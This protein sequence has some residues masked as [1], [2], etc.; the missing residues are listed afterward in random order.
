[1][2]ITGIIFCL[3]FIQMGVFTQE[4]IVQ[5]QFE[6]KGEPLS[7][8]KC[9]ADSAALVHEGKSYSKSPYLFS[10]FTGNGEGGLHLAYSYDGLKWESL[11][12]G[13]SFLKPE[14]GTD[15]LMRDPSVCVGP[16]GLFHMVWTSSWTDR[17]I[18]H[19]SSPDLI[20]W[21]K[22]QSI[23]VMMHEPEA[24][25]SWAPEIFYN[26]QDSLFYIFWAT[27]IPDRHSPIQYS[28]R[29]K[30]LN[31]R[32]YYVTTK[33]F[34]SFSATRMFFNP[35]FS[36]I[37]GAVLKWKDEFILFVKNENPNP[38]EKNIRYT[39]SRTMGENFP[40][41]VSAPITGKYWA[42]GPAPLIVDDY[43]YVY[44]DKYRE[45]RY[46]AVRSRDSR[47][48]E[49]VSDLVSFPGG[50]RHGTAFQVSESVLEKLKKVK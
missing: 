40:T 49:D 42:E 4:K 2:R 21:S 29:E 30:D 19:A 23:P 48:W 44:F 24:K 46:G 39:R 1:M 5:Q 26:E 7:T 36:V 43:I 38:A 16:D 6:S 8:H 32:Q 15:K 25:N 37:D 11:K 33:D 31:H 12:G 17:I 18:G 50:V 41:Q 14:V 3:I 9:T 13:D 45:R 10:Y 22:Q 28:E 20:N 34:I 47:N 35:D 27:T